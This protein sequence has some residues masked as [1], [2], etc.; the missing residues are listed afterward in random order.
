MYD[1]YM[2]GVLLGLDPGGRE[3]FGWAIIEDSRSLPLQVLRSGFAN[4]AAETVSIALDAA[5]KY[6]ILAAGIDAPLF[7][8]AGGERIADQKL[9]TQICNRGS[10]GGTVLHVNSLQGACLVQGM[11]AALLLRQRIPRL[12]LSESHPKALLW[13]LGVA[14]RRRRPSRVSFPD[15]RAVL[16]WRLRRPITEHDRDAAIGALSAWAMLH[17][18][19]G[20]EDFSLLDKD[21]LNPLRP[22]P[23]FWMPRTL[24]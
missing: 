21:C 18:P 10:H 8:S 3:S 6:R 15:L 14:T 2:S 1:S 9:R 12:P 19:S 17:Q 22:A 4:H 16:R 23:S 20:W 7:W 24:E 5:R 13:L 11:A